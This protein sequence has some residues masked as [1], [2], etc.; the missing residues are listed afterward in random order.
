MQYML[1]ALHTRTYRM[2]IKVKQDLSEQHNYKGSSLCVSFRVPT[3]F[4][5]PQV[6]L[7]LIVAVLIKL[8][9]FEHVCKLQ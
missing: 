8:V 3:N 7:M 4:V 9:I 2:T 1:T 6:V 5:W